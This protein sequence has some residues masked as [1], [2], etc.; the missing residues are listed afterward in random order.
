MF[1]PILYFDVG[2]CQPVL[3][4][5]GHL[6]R[7]IP[8]SIATRRH[9][10]QDGMGPTLETW[11]RLMTFMATSSGCCSSSW[12]DIVKNGGTTQ[13]ARCHGQPHAPECRLAAPWN[14]L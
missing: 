6:L 8:V 1:P 4:G 5:A 13:Y 9:T 10:Q 14:R 12:A 7:S 3:K 11:A 2:K